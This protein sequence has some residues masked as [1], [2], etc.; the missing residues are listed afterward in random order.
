MAVPKIRVMKEADFDFALH[1]T[2][3]EG[4]GNIRSDFER[5]SAY[6]PEGCFIAEDE[7]EP[8]GT[9]TTIAYGPLGW[10]GCLIVASGKRGCGTG[11]ALMQQAILY[12]Q[13]K[14]VEVIRLDADPPGMPLYRRFGFVEEGRSLRFQ[15]VGREHDLG[16]GIESMESS[17]LG[18]VCDL[19]ARAFGADRSRVLRR[20][21]KDFP[22]FC[23]VAHIEGSVTGY[24][25]GRRRA[26]GGWIGPW[27]CQPH[28]SHKSS[29]ESL[30]KTALSAFCDQPVEIGFLE[31][32]PFELNLLQRYGFQERPGSVRMRLGP[33][34]YRGESENIFG[35]VASSKG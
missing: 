3:G 12:L 20:L 27:V 11:T 31:G 33:D 25:M 26:A 30:L 1:L 18:K 15:G 9:V 29:A 5:F 10:I 14:G 19:D 28:A 32:N 2:Y 21:L 8:M 6:E 35:M 23:F 13:R 16:D 17:H 34:R 7:S 24:I 4:W 22:E